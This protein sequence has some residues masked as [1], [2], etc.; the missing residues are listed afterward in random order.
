M[1]LNFFTCSIINPT[2]IFNFPGTAK[3]DQ[4]SDPILR[5]FEIIPKLFNI[6]LNQSW[7]TLDLRDDEIIDDNIRDIH[8]HFLIPV[9]NINAFLA[10]YFN[11]FALELFQEG[12]MVDSFFE[13]IS[14]G[15]IYSKKGALNFV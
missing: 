11:I 9:I 7:F 14:K 12:V 15:F 2:D 3:I 8:T 4:I 1:T 6:I 5:P 10:F 13:G